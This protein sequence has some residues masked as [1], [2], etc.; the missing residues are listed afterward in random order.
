MA[1]FIFKPLPNIILG[2]YSLLRI[3]GEVEKFGSSFM[4]II[5]PMLKGTDLLKTIT[6]SLEKKGISTLVFDG[7]GSAAETA[8]INRALELARAAHIGGVIYAG[9]IAPAGVGRAVAAL[10]NESDDIYDYVEGKPCKADSLPFIA[11]PTTCRDPFSF[12]G[13]SPVLDSRNG[14]LSLLKVPEK[15]CSL[16]I[17]DPGCYSEVAPNAAIAMILQGIGMAFEGYSSTKTNF[18]SETVLGKAIELFLISL[19]P[20]RDKL[21]GV[22]REELIAQAA[23]LTSIGLASSAPGLGTAMALTCSGRYKISSSL[24]STILLPHVLNY[25][26]SSSLNKILILARMLKMDTKGMEPLAIALATI[27]EVRRLLAQANLPTRLKDLNL[28][29]EQL[30]PVA[31]DSMKLSFINYIPYSM[32]SNDIFEILKQAY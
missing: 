20:Q 18:F 24:I 17:F 10:Y 22:P 14:K 32:T 12:S 25:S 3:G 27:D 23:C 30:V 31:E 26:I 4:L 11:I 29:I 13:L 21:V 5:D 19:D 15:L 16:C 9:G 7:I 2:N 6:S 1:D 8:V 28:T